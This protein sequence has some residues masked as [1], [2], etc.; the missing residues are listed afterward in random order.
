M[1]SPPNVELGLRVGDG[2]NEERA[3]ELRAAYIAAPHP[4][5]R[6]LSG[7]DCSN[8]R[9]AREE[10]APMRANLAPS[11]LS[12][13]PRVEGAC[14]A[15]CVLRGQI[16]RY[17]PLCSCKA[18]AQ[19]LRSLERVEVVLRSDA[20]LPRPPRATPVAHCLQPLIKVRQLALLREGPCVVS[21]GMEIREQHESQGCPR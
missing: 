16:L 14:P 15:R 20:L 5:D 3:N 19:E 2:L 6:T 17:A 21:R 8:G 4:A 11:P 12:A 10:G 13:P 18:N 1:W 9:G 7:L